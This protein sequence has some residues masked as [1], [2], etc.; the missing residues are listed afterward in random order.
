MHTFSRSFSVGRLTVI[1]TTLAM[2]GALVV[3]L[4]ES[5]DAAKP[6]RV[7][8][9][10]HMDSM[11]HFAGGGVL[12]RYTATAHGSVQGGY[13]QRNKVI[14]TSFPKGVFPKLMNTRVGLRQTVG[15]MTRKQHRHCL[16][17]IDGDFF[18]FP[19]IRGMHDSGMSRGPRVRS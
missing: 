14:M 5:A 10:T 12:R 18:S 2:A 7:R 17:A 6:C 3:A 13:D 16:A 4:P 19:D 15:E 1:A 9:T 11:K 8:T